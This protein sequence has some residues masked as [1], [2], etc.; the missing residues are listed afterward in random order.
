MSAL[1]DLRLTLAAGIERD[2]VRGRCATCRLRRVVYRVVVGSGEP[3]RTEA[4][5]ATCWGIA[6]LTLPAGSR[7]V[8]AMQQPFAAVR[9]DG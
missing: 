7:S 1:L 6:P 9:A 2:M 4:R 3:G 8:S 5:C